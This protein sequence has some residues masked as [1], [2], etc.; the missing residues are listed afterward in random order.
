M[1]L[2]LNRWWDSGSNQGAQCVTAVGMKRHEMAPN[3]PET[4]KKTQKDTNRS[5]HGFFN[6]C[7]GQARKIQLCKVAKIYR[8][9]YG[10]GQVCAPHHT[11]VRKIS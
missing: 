3:R 10:G 1:L 9:L 11:N 7:H 5:F 4:D 8:R 2:L 6:F